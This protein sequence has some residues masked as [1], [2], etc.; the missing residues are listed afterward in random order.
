MSE[1]NLKFIDDSNEPIGGKWSF[2][3]ENRKKF[4]TIQLFRNSKKKRGQ[5]ITETSLV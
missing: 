4:R 2:D 3:E 1:K 5:N